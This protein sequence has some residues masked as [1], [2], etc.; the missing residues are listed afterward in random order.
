MPASFMRE[1]SKISFIICRFIIRF[2]IRSHVL[3]VQTRGETPDW[4]W[5][6]FVV[7]TPWILQ[8]NQ[9]SLIRNGFDKTE[10]KAM[11]ICT[12][13]KIYNGFYEGVEATVALIKV[14]RLPDYVFSSTLFC[15][16]ILISLFAC[17]YFSQSCYILCILTRHLKYFLEYITASIDSRK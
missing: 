5:F 4:S 3:Y 12:F 10:N 7:C 14:S 13:Q 16:S 9:H 1:P 6:V 15:F 17:T 8:T 11:N 2:I